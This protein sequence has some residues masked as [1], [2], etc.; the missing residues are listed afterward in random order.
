MSRRAE[1][2]AE[3]L[4]AALEEVPF[5]DGDWFEVEKLCRKWPDGVDVGGVT[6][7]AY[8]AVKA[9]KAAW[10]YGMAPAGWVRNLL[11]GRIA[12]DYRTMYERR[13]ARVEAGIDTATCPSP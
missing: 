9:R 6:L 5:M 4:V 2:P 8:H 3:R 1:T 12:V 11:A 13:M 10:A 7:S